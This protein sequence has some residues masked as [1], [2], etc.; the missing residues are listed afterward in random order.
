MGLL[1]LHFKL[2]ILLYSLAIIGMTPYVYATGGSISVV[3]SPSGAEVYIDG[4]MKG[5]APVL[6]S[7][8]T[9][10]NKVIVCKKS[11]YVDV[12][13][14]VIV[15]TNK[16]SAVNCRLSNINETNNQAYPIITPKP[17]KPPPPDLISVAFVFLIL[18]LAVLYMWT[19]GN[20]KLAPKQTSIPCDGKSTLPIKVQFVN[21]FGKLRKQKKDRD[22]ELESTS[23]TI[24]DVVIPA[25]KE[26]MEAMLTSSNEYGPVTITA[27]SGRQ[28]ATALVNSICNL[29]TLDIEVSP[30]TIPADGKSTATVIIKV[31]DEKGNYISSLSERTVELAITI[32]TI[33]TPINIP[34]STPAGVAI[35][36]AG[37]I[38]GTAKV[39]AS[40]CPLKKDGK[41]ITGEGKIIFAALAKRYCMHDGALMTMEAQNCPAC[42][43]IP[44]SGVDTKHCST[45]G[46]VLPQSAKFCDICGAKQPI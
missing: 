10:G 17:P 9:S 14:T 35:I 27:K 11:G 18:A 33:V 2:I 6:V 45:C 7:D 21:A 42:G 20:L 23:G 46:S 28:K 44:M 16:I 29:A 12:Q 36:K 1:K 13:Q 4:T 40:G 39:I 31:K 8:V 34:P 30:S 25:G 43:K 26:F 3:S 22:V 41:A 5:N 37:L 24:Q 15:S 32:G 19:K 38:S